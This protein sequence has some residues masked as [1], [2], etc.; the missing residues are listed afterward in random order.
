M[1]RAEMLSYLKRV[2]YPVLE[3]AAQGGLRQAMAIQQME[4]A[5]R[6]SVSCFEAVTRL[7]CGIAPWL[8]A[9][10]EEE[11]ERE[12]QDTMRRWA[13]AAID[14]QTNP[15]SP[16]YAD[17]EHHTGQFSQT[18][19]DAAF[20][21]QGILR[22]PKSLM[23]GMEPRVKTQVVFAFFATRKIRPVNNNWLLFSAMI[24]AALYAL[25]GELDMMR[26][27]YALCQMEGWYKGDGFY[28]DGPSFAMDYYN[29]YVI[30]PM[31]LDIAKIVPGMLP[32]PR[33]TYLSRSKRYGEILE[34]LIA[35]DGSFPAVGRSIAYRCGAF[36]LLAQLA[37]LEELPPSLPAGQVR[38]A[39]SAVIAKTLT[40]ASFRGDGFLS[41]G[42]CASQPDLGER[43]I[44]TG[45]LYLC[46]TAF[47]PLGCPPKSGFWTLPHRDW[48]QKKIWSGQNA[49]CDHKLG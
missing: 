30:H 42:L 41:V 26:M 33:E 37:L 11:E 38:A 48:T 2:A 6:E 29:S 32:V 34:R 17:F 40:P 12:V 7:I 14:H 1:E 5:Q 22:A 16:D 35:P 49:P 15:K 20:L 18:L 47:L 28:S 27:D 3:A 39:L 21:A 10:P 44:S 36:H 8:D 31:L 24:E 23:E 4:G 25:A 43:Y 19:V 45:S 9:Q 13:L 46:S